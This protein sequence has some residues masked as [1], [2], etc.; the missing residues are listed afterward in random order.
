M[1]L[2]PSLFMSL[3]SSFSLEGFQS[4]S[5]EGAGD[6]RRLRLE[7]GDYPAVLVGPWGEKSKLEVKKDFLIL[8]LIWQPDS[9]TFKQ[10]FNVDRLP[11]V[12]QSIF[13][14]VTPGGA[15]DMGPFKNAD[16]NLVL[17]ALGLGQNGAKWKFEDMIGKPAKIKVTQRPNPSNPL[18]PYTNVSAVS[19]L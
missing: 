3:P 7:E 11:T 12:R 2:K 1:K 5:F 15:L 10:K 6:T 17:G 19:K 8:E 13:L 18:D 16:L 14:D 4:G 9:D